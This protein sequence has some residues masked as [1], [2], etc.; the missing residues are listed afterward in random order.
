[1][2]TTNPLDRI[3][4]LADRLGPLANKTRGMRIEAGEWNTIEIT[5]RGRIERIRECPYQMGDRARGES[6]AGGRQTLEYVRHLVRL[7]KAAP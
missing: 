5:A 2:A 7:R 3:G 1:M 6:K 4:A